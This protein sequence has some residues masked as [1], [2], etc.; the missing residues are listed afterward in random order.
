MHPTCMMESVVY[1]AAYIVMTDKSEQTC[2]CNKY[3]CVPSAE[4][5]ATHHIKMFYTLA[6]VLPADV[7][8]CFKELKETGSGAVHLSG[9]L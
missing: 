2:C 5:P 3:L 1:A 6:F 7:V 9:E 8:K 4:E